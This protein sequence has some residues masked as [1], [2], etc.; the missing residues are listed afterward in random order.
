MS[1]A[2]AEGSSERGRA[3]RPR[4]PCEGLSI[5]VVELPCKNTLYCN[6]ISVWRASGL[7]NRKESKG[8]ASKWAGEVVSPRRPGTPGSPRWRWGCDA[9]TMPN[10]NTPPKRQR[11]QPG[12]HETFLASTLEVP[13]GW[14]FWSAKVQQF[15][16]ALKSRGWPLRIVCSLCR[17]GKRR[18]SSRRRPNA[19]KPK[20]RRRLLVTWCR[21]ALSTVAGAVAVA[22]G[23]RHSGDS[24]HTPLTPL[25]FPPCRR[26][27]VAARP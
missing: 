27:A 23:G 2:H 14:H 20:T 11:G 7:G 1:R 22:A 4:C 17:H 25:H 18:L 5:S 10:N 9:Q 15:S 6:I 12:S 3:G 21:P 16:A 26:T 19:E 13:Q 24:Q 8:R